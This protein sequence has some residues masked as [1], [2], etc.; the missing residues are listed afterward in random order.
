MRHQFTI[1]NQLGLH[2][3]PAKKVVAS[4]M[5]YPCSIFIE[6]DGSR[7]NA[8]SLVSILSAGIKFGDTVTLLTEGDGEAEA[9]LVI[10]ELLTAPIEGVPIRKEQ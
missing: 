5:S 10:G 8:K 3:R 1:Q 9:M 6:K 2:V 7:F 4:A